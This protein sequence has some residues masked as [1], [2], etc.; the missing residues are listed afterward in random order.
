MRD[1]GVDEEHIP[2]IIDEHHDTVREYKESAS[3]ADDLQSQLDTANEE[4]TERDNQIEQLKNS[5]DNEELQK[6][7]NE[8]ET[9]NADYENKLKQVQLDSAIKLA[10]A[11]EANDPSDVLAFIDKDGLEVAEDGTIKGLDDKLSTLKENKPYLFQAQKKTGRTPQEGGPAP[12]I[13]KEDFDKMSYTE[14]NDLYNNNKQLY[15]EFTK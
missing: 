4:I 14:K 10:V 2:K 11:K 6:K 9:S 5:T 15:D 13:T 7:L 12:S 8:Y 3:K 1:L